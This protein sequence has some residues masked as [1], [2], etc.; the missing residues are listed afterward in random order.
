MHIPDGFLSGRVIGASA[1]LAVGGL[2]FA[3][4]QA[5]QTLPPR[6][7]PLMGL[8]AAFVF[9]AQMVNFP[10]A[11]GTSGHLLGGVLSA[12]LLG[13]SAAVVVL[14]AVVMVQC[15]MF[16]DG[17]VLALGANVFN[18]GIVGPVGGYGVYRLVR[19]IGRGRRGLV[20]AAAFA[21]WASMVMASISCAGQL[22]LSGTVAWSLVFPAMINVHMLIGLGEG[23]VTALILVAIVRV[24]PELLADEPVPGGSIEI[25][26]VVGYGLLLAAGLALFVAPFAC[27]WP[28]GLEKVAASLGIQVRG[29]TT[30][31]LPSLFPDYH[32]PGLGSAVWGTAWA[33]LIGTMVAFGLA[34]LLA[35]ALVPKGETGKPF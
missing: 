6:R 21:G 22:A 24:R 3:L 9:A 17:G 26:G 23:L 12:V 33:G 29:Q 27:P 14:T 30:S 11:G 16:A 18:M 31:Q 10:V 8:A 34:W 32:L 4:R 35:L 2:G 19:W 13:P 1:I 15:L 20:W 28:D 5:R 25:R 7:I